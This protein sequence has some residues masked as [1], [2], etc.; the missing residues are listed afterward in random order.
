MIHD[1]ELKPGEKLPNELQ[2]SDMFGVSRGIMREALTQLQVLGYVK[3]MP[4]DGTIIADDTMSRFTKPVD[5]ILKSAVFTDLLDFK[6]ALDMKMMD[7]IVDRAT[8]EELNEIREELENKD[9]IPG[10]ESMG[11]YFHYQ[12][13]RASKNIFYMNFIDTY[14]DLLTEMAQQSLTRTGRIAESHEEHIAIITALL[15]RDKAAARR[16]MEEHIGHA[17]A[18]REKENRQQ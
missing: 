9:I 4:K 2:M 8:D 17:K 12:L 1:G 14:Y 16:A 11:H 3:R 6:E 5:D 7:V 18:A 15:E 10:S 13:A